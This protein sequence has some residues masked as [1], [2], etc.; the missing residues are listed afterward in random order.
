[1]LSQATAFA[2][3]ST[4]VRTRAAEHA[5]SAVPDHRGQPRPA[6]FDLF[7]D[8]PAAI[9]AVLS[10]ESTL[11]K[12][13]QE[14]STPLRA[15]IAVIPAAAVAG[16]VLRYAYEAVAPV[17]AV[18][19]TVA[20]V[21]FVAIAGTAMYLTRF[22]HRCTYV[23]E[24][25]LFKAELKG[26]RDARPTTEMMLFRDVAALK[27]PQT[28]HY[29]NGIYTGT[30]YEFRWIDA[31]GLRRF[32]LSG[33]HRG[34]HGPPK[35]FDAF[36]FAAAAEIAWSI[37]Y[38]AR[39]QAQLER[40][41]SIAFPVD[42]KRTVRVGPGFLEFHFGDEPVRFRAEEIGSVSLNDGSFSFK[43][44]DAKWFS[45]VGK[46]SFQYG[47]MANGKVFFLAL[48]KLMGYRWG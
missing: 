12:G 11:K 34:Q 20:A 28:R 24:D 38:L 32:R 27:A 6:E 14:M 13:R 1:M 30:N 9:G 4:R 19:T 42:S 5:L 43:H 17:R 18:P 40:E 8:P 33:T 45:R 37:H 10:A 35:A 2:P 16:V 7:A 25:G 22:A 26:R 31:A 21:F 39:A 47:Q 46:F 44:R 36:H 15:L 23:G 29:H 3:A 48:E 41:G